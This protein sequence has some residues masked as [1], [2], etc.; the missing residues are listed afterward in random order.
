MREIKF[1]GKDRTKYGNWLYGSYVMVDQCTE[2]PYPA[3]I[4]PRG[5]G[6]KKI[7]P[8]T[9][10]QYTGMKD[11]NG[12]EIYEGDLLSEPISP[13]G[14][15]DGGYLY[16]TRVIEWLGAQSGYKLHGPQAASKVIG[17]IHENP[18]LLEAS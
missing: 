14:G 2:D 17:N 1:R 12:V 11:C 6:H 18:E 3:I 13:V 15:K 9:L 10:G 5:F 8:E 4:E 16:K 7:I